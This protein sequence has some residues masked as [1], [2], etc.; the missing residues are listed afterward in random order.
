MVGGVK[1]VVQVAGEGDEFCIEAQVSTAPA[2]TPT[3][4]A[5]E[6]SGPTTPGPINNPLGPSFFKVGH[7]FTSFVPPSSFFYH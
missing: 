5:L 6:A 7:L 3:L 1:E 4:N 2:D